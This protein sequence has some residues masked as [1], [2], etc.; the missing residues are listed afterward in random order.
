M[1]DYL[2][3][4]IGF[5]ICALGTDVDYLDCEIDDKW[6]RGET[7]SECNQDLDLDIENIE[8]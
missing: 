8:D 5:P 6:N 4:A 3:G 2:D 7:L 1:E